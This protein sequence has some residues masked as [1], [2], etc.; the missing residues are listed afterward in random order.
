MGICSW[1]SDWMKRLSN[2]DKGTN[3]RAEA[4]K[5]INQA[6]DNVNGKKRW[7]EGMTWERTKRFNTQMF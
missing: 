2:S 6:I 3:A 1:G 5:K 7:L 4:V